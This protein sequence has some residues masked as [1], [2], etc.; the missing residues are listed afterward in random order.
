MYAPS[1]SK[2]S[3]PSLCGNMCEYHPVNAKS[4]YW[5]EAIALKTTNP[6]KNE[7]ARIIP[8]LSTNFARIVN[9]HSFHDARS[10]LA[11]PKT[12]FIFRKVSAV[13]RSSIARGGLTYPASTGAV[14]FESHSR[15]RQI[16]LSPAE[17]PG[18]RG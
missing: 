9:V 16:Y 12:R 4:T 18:I 14:S 8:V 7:I 17:N 6:A 10:N 1:L 5:A 11:E 2:N 13:L 3:A 15:G